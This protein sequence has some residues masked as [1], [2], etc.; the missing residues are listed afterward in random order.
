MA[1]FH[2]PY[3]KEGRGVS[4]DPFATI[5]EVGWS[6]YRWGIITYRWTGPGRDLDTRTRVNG[7]AVLGWGREYSDGPLMMWGGDTVGSSGEETV[8]IDLK[9]ARELMRSQGQSGK[10]GSLTIEC[11]A[12]WWN[13]ENPSGNVELEY[14]AYLG[15]DPKLHFTT[16]V[17]YIT[18]YSGQP[19]TVSKSGG[20]SFQTKE[21]STMGQPLGSIKIDYKGKGTI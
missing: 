3:G 16:N 5:K 21:E 7:R 6:G 12:F 8:L 11:N 4:L 2:A 20:I 10:D 1:V 15:G 18:S 13:D 9:R 14:K 17:F 19:D